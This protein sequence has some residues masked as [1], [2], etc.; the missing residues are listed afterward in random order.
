MHSKIVRRIDG[1]SGVFSK[2]ASELSPSD[3]QSLLLGVYQTRAG[4][5]DEADIMARARQS[6]LFAA[7]TID[8]RLLSR[9]DRHAFACAEGFDAMDLAPVCPFGTTSVLGGIDQNNV[10][11][12]IRN[13]DVLGD[14]TPAL[15]L[16]CTQRR[17]NPE[18]RNA[19]I[20]LVASHRV[21]RLQPFDKP[22]FTPHFRLFA[23]ATAGRDIGSDRFEI[24][25][26]REHIRFYL[27][28][29]R[30]LNED[31]FAI[32]N[33]LVEIS[34]V[35]LTRILLKDLGVADDLRDVIRAHRSGAAAQFLKERN[36]TLPSDLI[37]PSTLNN[38]RL[39]AV[40]FEVCDRL[41]EEFPEATF[42]F[43]LARLEGIGYY[44]GLCLRI[45]PVASDRG[46][47]AV[48]DG[49]FVDWTARL[50]QDR[51]ERLLTSGIGSEFVC[52]AYLKT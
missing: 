9:F 17:K 52:R 27:R 15:A 35:A 2:L 44:S 16:E 21:L 20:R 33:P 31:G 30:A 47:Y 29:F 13:A 6:P 24:D 1:E 19:V 43:N 49:G 42:R 14:S 23:L 7:S 32:E 25:S 34:D 48:A 10:L 11:T 12:A 51:K 36:I 41:F 5:L 3:L 45:S 39:K 28:L 4:K 37:D 22:G 40:K 26:L 18:D 46:R 38:R 8:A 50:L